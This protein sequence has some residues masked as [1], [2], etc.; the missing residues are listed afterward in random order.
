METIDSIWVRLV[1]VIERCMACSRK[2]DKNVEMHLIS[3]S[4]LFNQTGTV[5]LD[6]IKGTN[7]FTMN[8]QMNL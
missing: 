1:I 6:K 5:E 8:L 7:K 2:I 3:L 4:A